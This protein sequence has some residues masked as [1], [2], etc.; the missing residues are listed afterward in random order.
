MCVC[1]GERERESNVQQKLRTNQDKRYTSNAVLPLQ[2]AGRIEPVCMHAKRKGNSGESLPGFMRIIQF[3]SE[4]A[5]LVYISRNLIH[6]VLHVL[7]SPK[8]KKKKDE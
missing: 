4:M 8:G 3:S 2:C 1:V 5:V 7:L 6:F